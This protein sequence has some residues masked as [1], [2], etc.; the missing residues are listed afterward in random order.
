MS[1]M[2]QCM[3]EFCF[4]DIL[5]KRDATVIKL[6]CLFGRHSYDRLNLDGETAEQEDK[7]V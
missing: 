6:F 4:E 5:R 2:T 7:S 3:D 1:E